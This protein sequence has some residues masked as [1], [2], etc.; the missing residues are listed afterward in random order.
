[1]LHLAKTAPESQ[2]H[3]EVFLSRYA[4]LSAWALQLAENDQERAEDL[5]HDAFVQF[6]LAQ[7]DL[8]RIQ[9]L[10]GYLYC[11]LRNLHLSQLRRSARLSHSP[12]SIVDYDSAE[13]GLRVADPRQQIRLQDELRQICQYACA[14]KESSKAG[15]V[16]I[17]RFLH[18]YYPREIAL[19][20]RSTRSAVEERLRLARSEARQFLKDPNSLHFMHSTKLKAAQ[21]GF[22]RPTHEFLKELRQTIF[23]SCQGVCLNQADL[24]KLYGPDRPAGIELETL[25]HVSSCAL[26]LDQ[27][28]RILNLPL[29][30]E[31]FP[32]DTL[33]TDKGQKGDH[34]G[35]GPGGATGGGP[36]EDELRRCRRRAQDVVEH[37]PAELRISVNGYL[38]AAQNVGSEVSEQTVTINLGEKIEFVEILGEQE[39]RLLFL[40]VEDLPPE[41][42]YQQSARVSLSEQ[43]ALEATLSFTSPWPTL[44]VLYSDP[45]TAQSAAPVEAR[46]NP[47]VAEEIA[48][49]PALSDAESR[50]LLAPNI[51]LEAWRRLV[52]ADLIRRPI[53]ATVVISL[54]LIAALLFVR[55]RVT[56]VSA[57]E[58][59]QRSIV[60][61]QTIAA[62]PSI[63]LHRTITLEER[64]VG[65][66]D[67]TGN[68][69]RRQRIEQ[70]QS[71]AR[72]ISLRRVFDD[73][74]RLVAGE[75]TKTDGT[76][77]VYV[78]GQ[79]PQARTSPVVAGQAILE[80][81]ELWRLDLSALDLQTLISDV[82]Q[83]AVADNANTYVLGYQDSIT[84]GH[85]LVRAELTLNKS[86]LRA[87]EQRLTIRRDN[88]LREF[89]FIEAGFEQSRPDTIAPAVFQPD[90]ELLGQVGAGENRM[91][92]SLTSNAGVPEI[93]PALP[94]TASR[95]LEIEVTYL[96]D[97][98]KAN[99]GEQVGLTRT[100]AG[101]LRVDALVETEERK[102]E[103]VR[104]LG[105]LMN[106]PAVT[107]D[108][109]TVA[110]AVKRDSGNARSPELPVSDIE[111]SNGR[112]PADVELRQYFSA[113]L[114]GST[115]VDQ[116]ITRYAGRVMGHSRQ[117]L[118]HA[119]ALKRLVERF[120]PDEVRGLSPDAREKFLTMVQDHSRSYQRAVAALRQELRPIFFRSGESASEIAAESRAR[121][122]QLL[123]L[124]YANDDAVRSAFTISADGRT[125]ANIKTEQ[126]W[127]SLVTA[128][129]LAAEI[130]IAYQK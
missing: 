114:I 109:R 38:I 61:E 95:E 126:F 122:N 32:T 44:R 40:S 103:I 6:N 56:T 75:W 29:L 19:L 68:L 128:E 58:L 51:F 127:R 50:R 15:S 55:L 107:I 70:W 81:G 37:R 87:V 24:E 46:S 125:T 65:P 100:A 90:P 25:A 121:A 8:S 113:R 115:A 78:P 1:M 30:R 93:S 89:R 99:L 16:M 59:L 85:S 10:D 86:D 22:A 39:L 47:A 79:R 3:E 124:S 120:S 64:L 57:G 13:L 129:K 119:S 36:T 60:S 83:L 130:Q 77:L 54:L 21:M 112:I 116:E 2:N 26:C 12:L 34:G 5:V 18:G 72:G 105:P 97:R 74:N 98:I 111:V 108:V 73:Q 71:A 7:P 123:K 43:R 9:N 62:N 14:R 49:A 11:L 35:G 33:G 17:L 53:T 91:E 88:Q 80:T 66:D 28:N 31:R 84:G 41:G 101:S 4:R 52:G 20:M 67:V 102:R 23:D 96:L 69:V 48:H 42:E 76:S 110:E 106:N 63:V 82:N 92:P 117:A 27:T 94:A 45:L 104:A 118:L